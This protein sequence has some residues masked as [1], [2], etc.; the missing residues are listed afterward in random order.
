MSDKNGRIIPCRF[1]GYD[2]TNKDGKP[3]YFLTLPPEWLGKHTT[4]EEQAIEA[5]VKAGLSSKQL[6]FAV[7]IAL[8]D[9]YCLPGMESK[10]W[11]FD[12]LPSRLIAWVNTAVYANYKQ[13]QV[14]EKKFYEPLPVG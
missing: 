13:D 11:D 8:L 9:D 10:K 2:E 3:K 6:T 7:S 1:E 5:G 12:L 14:I 4:I